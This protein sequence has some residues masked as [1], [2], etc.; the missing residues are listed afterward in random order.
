MRILG[1]DYGSKRIGVAVCD[2]LAMTAQ[3][4]A[5]IER[6]NKKK[7][8]AA[9]SHYVRAYGVEKIVIGYPLRL[10]ATTG[11]QCEK[12]DR[13]VLQLEA[14]FS[15]PVI[16]RDESFTTK[17]AEEILRTANIR[18]KKRR[19]VVDKIAAGLILQGYLDSLEKT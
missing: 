19:A 14:E 17:D 15:I 4:L 7:D 10:D 2:E 6:K 11:I 12:V 1:L 8:L 18:A 9:L 13:F 5:V 16:R 3:G